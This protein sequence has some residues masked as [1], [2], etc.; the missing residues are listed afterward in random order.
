MENA[1]SS[2]GAGSANGGYSAPGHSN[3]MVRPCFE[4]KEGSGVSHGLSSYESFDS[5]NHGPAYCYARNPITGN[6]KENV[7]PYE[8]TYNSKVSEK[9][10]SMDLF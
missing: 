10:I 9:G 5:E 1:H 8:S 6:A 2:W 3:E 4:R 7:K